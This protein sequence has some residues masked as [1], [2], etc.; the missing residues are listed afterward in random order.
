M[1]WK[2]DNPLHTLTSEDQN[3]KAVELWEA[4]SLG[5]ITEDNNRLPQPVLSLLVLTI[6]TAFLI[7]FPLWGQRPTAAIYEEYIALMDTPEVQNLSDEKAMQYI[8]DKVKASGSKWAPLQERHPV[9]MDDLRMIKAQV[10]ELQN[11]RARL[12]EYSIV[13]DK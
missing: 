8:V 10:I 9:E 6:I 2:L 3:Q 4:E 13:G 5:G 1:A 7:T 11:K 12:D